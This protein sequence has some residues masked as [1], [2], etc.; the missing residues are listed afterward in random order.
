MWAVESTVIAEE[1]GRDEERCKKFVGTAVSVVMFRAAHGREDR[2]PPSRPFD[3]STHRLFPLLRQSLLYLMTDC[4]P[5]R[6]HSI[7]PRYSKQVKQSRGDGLCLAHMDVHVSITLKAKRPEPDVPALQSCSAELCV[8]RRS[9][10]WA[11][12]GSS[13]AGKC[14]PVMTHVSS[15]CPSI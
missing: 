12:P 6:K 2:T 11:N 15:A 10:T 7:M 14:A 3:P 1:D 4:L 9:S 5:I 8:S 13:P